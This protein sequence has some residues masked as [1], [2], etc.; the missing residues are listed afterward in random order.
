MNVARCDIETEVVVEARV[1]GRR[2]Q[3]LEPQPL[4]L[5]GLPEN[6]TL[7]ELIEHVVLAEVHAFHERSEERRLVKF[8]T[9]AE[10]AH[11]A[12][13]GKVSSGGFIDADHQTA[14]SQVDP[15]QAVATALLA[16]EDGL[17]QVV[18]DGTPTDDLDALLAINE[19]SSLMFIRLV[20]LAGG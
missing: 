20:A 14:N 1:L 19:G 3:T 10:I 8:L 4:T 11:G 13:E 18:V 2:K 16:H 5:T 9:E 15:A 12:E 7:R 6:P 17:F